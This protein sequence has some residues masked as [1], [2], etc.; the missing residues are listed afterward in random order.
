MII[1]EK[2][3]RFK[4]AKIMDFVKNSVSQTYP[5]KKAIEEAER[6]NVRPLKK[7]LAVI[8]FLLF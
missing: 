5:R 4:E 8:V 1:Q 3:D 7:S 6:N 2:D